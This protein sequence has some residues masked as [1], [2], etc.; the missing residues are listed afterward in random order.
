[1]KGCEFPT[2]DLLD[3]TVNKKI[4]LGAWGWLEMLLLKRYAGGICL[5]INSKA[6]LTRAFAKS[7][8]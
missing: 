7:I 5:R 1:M 8:L 6:R 2:A 3:L 4:S